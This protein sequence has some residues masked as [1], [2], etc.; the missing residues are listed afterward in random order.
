MVPEP[1]VMWYKTK[2]L[3]L[4]GNFLVKKGRGCDICLACRMYQIQSLASPP[5]KE[6]DRVV[7]D[8]KD[9]CL[10][11]CRVAASLIDSNDL[12]GHMI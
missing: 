8:K 12:E 4:K 11:H 3:S 7:D 9:H 6:K 2:Y 5:L 1:N 10:R